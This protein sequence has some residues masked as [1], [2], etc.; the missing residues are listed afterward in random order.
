MSTFFRSLRLDRA[1]S[2]RPPIARGTAASSGMPRLR[3]SSMPQLFPIAVASALSI[4]GPLRPAPMSAPDRWRVRFHRGD[5]SVLTASYLEHFDQVRIA[6]R[7]ILGGA[8]SDT[9][10]HNVFY[11]LIADAKL[12]ENFR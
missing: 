3:P 8:D 2:V 6:V 7:R 12:R 5:R 1:P 11:R 4:L 10:V 9:V